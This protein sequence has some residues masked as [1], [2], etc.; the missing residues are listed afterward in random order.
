[1]RSQVISD[2]WLETYDWQKRTWRSFARP[3]TLF[4]FFVF[5]LSVRVLNSYCNACIIST[6][7]PL[8]QETND[9]LHKISCLKI[10]LVLC[11]TSH[12]LHITNFFFSLF[13]SRIPS[14]IPSI[15]Y[16][17]VI[18]LPP[19]SRIYDSTQMCQHVALDLSY[20]IFHFPFPVWEKK[21][22]IK[23]NA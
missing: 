20:D 2:L 16:Q 13:S 6:K 14:P 5:H 18:Y 1:M 4:W 17:F 7:Y 21:K 22:I 12:M 19:R 8:T 23:W 15:N 10:I 9:V 3:P 11:V